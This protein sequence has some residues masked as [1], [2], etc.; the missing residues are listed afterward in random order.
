MGNNIK[1]LFFFA[2]MFFPCISFGANTLA[3]PGALGFGAYASGGRGGSVYHVTNL[4]DTGAGSFRASVSGSNRI[5]VFDVGGYIKLSSAVSVSSNI[6]IAG[7]TAPGGGIGFMGGEISFAKKSNI[8]CR[9]IRVV[10]GS[11][12]ESDEDDALS[13]YLAQNVI[14]DHCSFEFAP[15]NNVDGVGNNN[16]SQAVTN[17]TFQYCLNADPTGQQFG[18]HCESVIS[19]WA[20][21]FNIFANSHNRNPLAKTNDVFMNNVL[22]NCSA[23]YTTHTSTAFKHDIINNYFILGPACTGTDNTWYQIDKNQS[24]Y[25]SGNIKDSDKDGVLDGDTTTPYWYQGT[26]TVLASPWST[27]SSSV[28]KYT[29]RTGYRIAVSMAGTRPLDQ[30]DSLIVNQIRTLG[31]GTTGYTTGTSGPDENYY[32]S[33][34][35]TGLGNS[36]YGTIASGV[37]D[38][39]TDNDGMPDYWEKTMDLNISTNDAMTKDA[40]GYAN[41]ENYM[42]LLGGFH[43]KTTSGNFVTINLL[44]YTGG[45]SDA[46]PT[47]TVS[48]AVNGAAAMSGTNSAK[49]TPASGFH[50]I[51]SFDF[52]VTGTDGA[53]FTSTVKIAVVPSGTA[54]VDKLIKPA[55]NGDLL[56]SGNVTTSIEFNRPVS[57]YIVFDINGRIVKKN[58]ILTS[59]INRADVTGISDGYYIVKAGN[60]REYRQAGFLKKN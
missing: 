48:N 56:V 29:A 28:T 53:S 25:C 15:W 1:F 41:I 10:P 22:Y 50:G 32:T 36:G 40:A 42:N 52:T 55:C 35:Q 4:N 51:G 20:W 27:L 24:I 11:L 6:T 14:L 33:Q 26:G 13:L 34:S 31:S 3:F 19:N 7:Q 9:Y 45:F 16:D 38:T 18:A 5:V 54:C 59:A 44:A 60:G 8:I 17:I 30:L 23:G 12:T 43:G 46:S 37:K 49:F 2:M 39:D 57:S 47:Y 21:F 58:L